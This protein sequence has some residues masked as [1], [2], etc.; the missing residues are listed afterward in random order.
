MLIHALC[1]YYDILAKTGQV[2]PDGYSLV[3]IHYLISLT[4]D[5][6]IDDIISQKENEEI[7]TAK[8]KV[9]INQIPKNMKMPQRTEKTGI[10][11]NIIEHRPLYI[12]GLNVEDRILTTQDRTEKAKKSHEAFVHDNLD[13]IEGLESPIIQAYRNFLLHWMPEKETE[14]S[15]LL[16][17]GKE[18]GKSGFAFCLSGYPE[19]LLHEDDLIKKRWEEHY[20]EDINNNDKNYISQCAVSGENAPIA[21]IH[22]KIKGVYGGLATG[23]VLIGFNNT[24]ENS[25]GKEQSYNSNISEL[26]MRKY[27]E[28]LNYL[29]EKRGHKILLD[30]VTIVFWAMEAEKSAED[31]IMAML[32][33]QSDKMNA[34]QTETMLKQLLANSKK[35]RITETQL[36]SLGIIDANVDFYMIGLKPNSS[37]IALKFIYHRKY[38]DIL[39]NIAKFQKDLQI[40]DEIHPFSLKKIKEELISPK[41]QNDK[42][43]PALLTKLFEAIIYGRK[44][45][46]ALL[47]TIVERVKKDTDLKVNAIR[48]GIIKACIQRKFQREEF[49]MSLNKLN[50]EPAYLCGRLFAVLEKLQQDASGGSLNR[51]IKNAYFASA[52]SK[53]VMVF[54][55]LILLA[56]N[57]LDKVKRLS[58]GSSYKGMRTG[59]YERLIQEIIDLMEGEFP[60][61]FDLLN[62]GRFIVGYYQQM[63]N[64]F[65]KNE[66]RQNGKEEEEN[67]GN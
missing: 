23:S 50:V 63:Q 53:P 2:L 59:T 20:Q 15:F 28:A 47:S 34:K 13:F 5:G 26:V 37:R 66:T 21:R 32:Y 10:E 44:Y 16:G 52:A 8:G 43:N 29:L 57:H 18:Y 27:T 3:K 49:H 51:T 30:D 39:W 61:S 58:Q 45:P 56:Q 33:G 1:D 9:K 55:K 11:A 7:I 46:E 31:L 14:N 41:S 24:S 54:P 35:G 40:T 38:A 62:Q 6:E 12:F 17:L 60:G 48:A 64:F 4:E 19:I 25:Y 42:V 22:S 36:Q 65:I 67:H